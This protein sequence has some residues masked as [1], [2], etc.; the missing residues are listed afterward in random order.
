MYQ[1]KA[2]NLTP[3]NV[4]AAAAKQL[5]LGEH[6]GCLPLAFVLAKHKLT[7]GAVHREARDTIP[8]LFRHGNIRVLK[9]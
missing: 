2:L 3:R 4:L 1:A 5:S 6:S 9:G 7:S 8:P